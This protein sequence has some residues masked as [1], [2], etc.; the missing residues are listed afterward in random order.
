MIKKISRFF[1]KS[2]NKVKV[3]V[4]PKGGKE[5]IS[6]I[7]QLKKMFPEKELQDL[8]K[9]DALN[10]I[11][12]KLNTILASQ[13][14]KLKGIDSDVE[15][16]TGFNYA[17]VTTNK[18]LYAMRAASQPFGVGFSPDWGGLFDIFA[19]M[20]TDAHIQGSIN[21][22]VEGVAKKDFFISNENGE[23]DTKGTNILKSQWF[24][25]FIKYVVNVR[26][27]GFGLIQIES[28]NLTDFSICLKEVNRKH[29]RPDLNGVVK[30][31]YDLQPFKKWD[32]QPYKSSCIYIFDNVLGQLNACVR[33]YVYKCEI[34]RVWA[35]YNK[36]Y[37]IPPIIAKTNLN[38]TVR[39][40]NAVDGLENWITNNYIV[41]DLSDEV[42]PFDSSG[43]S[44]GSGQQFF[45]NLMRLCDEQ[46]SKGLLS[47]TMTMDAMG[48][49]YKGEVHAN[50][51]NDIIDSIART[52]SYIVTKELLPRLRNF[53]FPFKEGQR[54][55][56][57]NSEKITMKEKAEIL[58]ILSNGGY[59]V[60][61][62]VASDFIGL[63]LS[64]KEE[65]EEK[66]N[67]ALQ[68]TAENKKHL[69]NEYIK[70]FNN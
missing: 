22:L 57:D 47:S 53:G 44:G 1:R 60:D 48:G 59:S 2:N 61:I 41:M 52:V 17:A 43:K 50:T 11:E 30:R 56:I 64:E 7:E 51:T 62:V 3:R 21:K 67:P 49:N 18:W 70:K 34:A 12:N 23:H 32:K 16:M 29:V 6:F 19:N 66:I 65:K 55:E 33:W 25:D 26:L 4:N 63:E 35:K 69:Q 10:E 8:A 15:E 54:L 42:M 37:G 28:L 36:T 39:K 68:V 46:M 5:K 24:V 40:Q 20:I 27:W 45:E 31:E 13:Q 58:S 14:K 38:D 9:T